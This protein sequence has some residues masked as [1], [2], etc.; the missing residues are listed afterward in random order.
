LYRRHSVG[1]PAEGKDSSCCLFLRVFLSARGMPTEW[2][3]YN[4]AVRGR[5]SEGELAA[6]LNIARR[7]SLSVSKAK[8]G[9]G[10]S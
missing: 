1:A 8:R 4:P 2:R 3:P 9:A 10:R 6:Q 5:P 7:L